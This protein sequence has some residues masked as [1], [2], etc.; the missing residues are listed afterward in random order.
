MLEGVL[1]SCRV[2]QCMQR[3]LD[4]YVRRCSRQLQG[5]VVYARYI[6]HVYETLE[7]KYVYIYIHV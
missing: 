4:M 1:D 7:M 6:R 5:V 3:I 2:L